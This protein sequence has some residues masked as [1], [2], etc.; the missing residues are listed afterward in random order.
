MARVT[1]HS[2]PIEAKLERL[3]LDVQYEPEAA[4]F[5]AA[6]GLYWFCADNYAGQGD[7][8]YSILSQLGFS[9]GAMSNG[10]NS[11]GGLLVHEALTDQELDPQELFAWLEGRRANPRR[12]ARRNPDKPAH[13][14]VV[15]KRLKVGN[16]SVMTVEDDQGFYV[17]IVQ[18]DTVTPFK[19][20][21]TRAE[22]LAGA[23]LAYET[24]KHQGRINPCHTRRRRR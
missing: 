10:P 5:D 8:L 21:A 18:G 1:Q 22:A 3:G 4:R 11:E 17:V 24:L 6:E 13:A 9:P 7:P 12:R 14:R 15:G 16:T 20:Y 19:D 2:D 23:T